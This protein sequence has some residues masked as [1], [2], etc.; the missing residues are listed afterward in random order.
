MLP[1]LSQSEL[2][3]TSGHPGCCP[4]EPAGAAAG[5]G[6]PTE[7]GL[8]LPEAPTSRGGTVLIAL[9]RWALSF[10][11]FS[12]IYSASSVCPFCGT[13]GCPVG[14]GAAGL[15]GGFFALAWQYGAGIFRKCK[16]VAK[17]IFR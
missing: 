3:H 14:A 6:K 4:P 17:R 8:D 15:V 2:G 1:K 16:E 10:L 7:R 11:A 12:G 5:T 13:P 9:K